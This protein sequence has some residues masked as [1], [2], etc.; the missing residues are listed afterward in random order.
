MDYTKSSS[1]LTPPTPTKS[2]PHLLTLLQALQNTQYYTKF[3]GPNTPRIP[4]T[5]STPILPL[6][7]PILY[8]P[9]L[10][11]R[12]PPMYTYMPKAK[13]RPNQTKPNHQHI[14]TSMKSIYA[15]SHQNAARFLLQISSRDAFVISRGCFPLNTR[16]EEEE[17]M[18]YSVSIIEGHF[19]RG[20]F[21]RGIVLS[22][23]VIFR[24]CSMMR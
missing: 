11:H 22:W 16:K 18:V 17:R 5:F 12:T 15:L 4:P 3:G 1:H 14:T 7:P 13:T 10:H 20:P 9:A 24:E 8:T 19:Y 2:P 23:R 6:R 21:R